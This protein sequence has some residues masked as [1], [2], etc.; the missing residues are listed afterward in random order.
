M[1]RIVVSMSIENAN[2][3]VKELVEQGW[4]IKYYGSKAWIL[5]KD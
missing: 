2:L 3:K 5:G 1:K 4:K